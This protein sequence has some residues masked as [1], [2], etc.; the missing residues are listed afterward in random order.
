MRQFTDVK[1]F[2]A[3]KHATRLELGDE[4]TAWLARHPGIILVDKELVQSSDD[5]FHCLTL[6]LCYR[7]PDPGGATAPSTGAPTMAQ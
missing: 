7:G 6:T 2:S 4:V 3:T 5:S 1:V